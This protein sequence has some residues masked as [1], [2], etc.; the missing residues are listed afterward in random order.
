VYMYGAN[1]GGIS[2]P[3]LLA[4][5]HWYRQFACVC[6]KQVVMATNAWTQSTGRFLAMAA[7]ISTASYLGYV[8]YAF[9]SYGK[10]RLTLNAKDTKSLLNRVMPTYEVMDSRQIGI[11]APV[12]ATFNSACLID[13]QRSAIIRSIFKA[14]ALLLGG[15]RDD[16]SQS[17]GL[18]DQ[19]KAWGWA[20]LGERP[21]REIVFGA[22]TQPWIADLTFRAVPADDFVAFAEPNYVK[23]A[24]NLAAVP[25]GTDKSVARTETRVIATNAIARSKF[26]MYWAFLSPGIILIRR[27]ALRL[28]KAEAEHRSATIRGRDVAG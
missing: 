25:T 16:V 27:V 1:R 23:I 4:G 3:Q 24:W 11:G 21:G 6:K 7:G 22:V 28:V 8:A 17:P 12:E 9:L 13:L 20:V 5:F 2:D 15:K 19:A 26:R 18:V 10:A 14:R